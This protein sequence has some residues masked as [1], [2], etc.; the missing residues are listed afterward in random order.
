MKKLLLILLLF[1][2]CPSYCNAIQ[3]TASIINDTPNETADSYAAK[4][5]KILNYYENLVDKTGMERYLIAAKYFYYQANRIDISNKNAYVGRARVALAQNKVRDAK[6]NLFLALN[7]DE[8]NPKVN[9]YLGESFF[10]DGEFSEAIKYY[11][12]AYTHGYRTNYKTNLKLGICYEKLDDEARAK[13][14]YTNAVKSDSSKKEAKNRLQ[15]LTIKNP[16]TKEYN[17][18]QN[19]AQ[20]DDENINLDKEETNS[21]PK[22]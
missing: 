2:F 1:F 10:Q 16:G 8:N 4:G 11:T 12:E 7:F 17:V 5:D 22:E 3:E 19:T 9:F 6:N 18:F 20:D 21:L 13:Y 14:Y 15:N